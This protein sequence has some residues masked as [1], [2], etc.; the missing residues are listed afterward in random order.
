MRFLLA[1]SLTLLISPLAK[2]D[3]YGQTPPPESADLAQCYA[4]AA[5]QAES[6]QIQKE[7]IY[8]LEQQ[9]KQILGLA[10]PNVNFNASEKWQDTSGVSGGGV[11]FQSPQPQVGFSLSQ[12]IF[13]GFR[14]F[15]AMKSYKHQGEAAELQLRHARTVLYQTTANA[16]YLVVNLE[17]ALANARLAVSLS[18][19]RIQELKRFEDLGKS[20]HSE[21][22][23]VESQE[24]AQEA[25]VE[26]LKGQ[27]DAARAL[28]SFVTGKDMGTAKLVDRIERVRS[29]GDEE[30][31]LGRAYGRS[32]VL[33]LRK[34]VS[35]Q[36]D[37]VRI[38]KG[39]W[40]P[41]ISF[42]GNAYVKRNTTLDPIKWDATLTGAVPLFEGGSQLASVRQA[43]S[44]LRSA[45]LS[46][47]LGMRQARSD[48]H[49]AY[50]ALRAAVAGAEAAERAYLKADETYKLEE[51]EY[52]LGLVNNLDVLTAMNNL[53]GAKNAFDGVLIQTK[54]DLLQLKVA[55]EELP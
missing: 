1:A 46:L 6:L 33:A 25:S 31:S 55:A 43:K 10:L 11:F 38:A 15:A 21:V 45:E 37:Q 3:T 34:L 28:L 41:T 26:S 29:L 53:V 20:R 49:S 35:A 19:S 2:A 14:E 52:R 32:D 30:T 4:W 27:V 9:V 39:A 7:Q 13:S 48:I 17:E 18:T 42:L 23:L 51:K 40:S 44:S 50:A 36:E 24:A 5:E 8:Q 22:T 54:V 47:E 16:F 12:A